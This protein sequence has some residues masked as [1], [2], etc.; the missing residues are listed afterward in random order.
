[1]V[2]GKTPGT[3]VSRLKQPRLG[4]AP[5]PSLGP[6]APRPAGFI[7]RRGSAAESLRRLDPITKQSVIVAERLLPL[8]LY[9]VGYLP[10]KSLI[11]FQAGFFLFNAT[12]H[13]SIRG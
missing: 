1:M 10:T 9:V 11:L 13:T 5:D 4:T 8:K 2:D 6:P 12:S 3:S 7:D